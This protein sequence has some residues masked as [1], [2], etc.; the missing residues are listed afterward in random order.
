MLL[1]L[2][3]VKA[4]LAEPKTVCFLSKLLEELCQLAFLDFGAMVAVLCECFPYF[5]ERA[6]ISFE[7]SDD[8]VFWKI[9]VLKLL[10]DN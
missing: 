1:Q 9:I 10:D 5:H 8:V 2:S 7:I 4:F 3:V 6:Q